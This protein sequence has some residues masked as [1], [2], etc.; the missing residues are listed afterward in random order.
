MRYRRTL[1]AL[2]VLILVVSVAP[3]IFGW[4]GW[5]WEPLRLWLAVVTIVAVRTWPRRTA[6]LAVIAWAAVAAPLTVRSGRAGRVDLADTTRL[7]RG[8][9]SGPHRVELGP[10]PLGVVWTRV[11]DKSYVN[12]ESDDS[13]LDVVAWSV[14]WLPWPHVE[15]DT[16][17]GIFDE[18]VDETIVARDGH[19]LV[20]RAGHETRSIVFGP[21]TSWLTW[22][23]WLG[24]LL[25]WRRRR[26]RPPR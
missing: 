6:T 20:V 1:I 23:G 16:V 11:P 19:R 21:A 13:D 3:T 9:P 2:G 10:V 24:V 17:L 12:G 5:P 25:A 22:L 8:V 18:D 4:T 14:T 7:A 26:R 15:R